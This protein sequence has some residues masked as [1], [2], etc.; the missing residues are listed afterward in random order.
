MLP[1]RNSN[2]TTKCSDYVKSIFFCLPI[3]ISNVLV[4]FVPFL[5]RTV[6]DTMLSKDILAQYVFNFEVSSKISAVVLLSL[7]ILIWPNIVDSSEK[8]EKAKYK[9]IWFKGCFCIN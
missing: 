9:K 5:E 7:K 6:I 4:M 3:V 8:E 1:K 2:K